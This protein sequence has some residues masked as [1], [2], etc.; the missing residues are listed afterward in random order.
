MGKTESSIN[1]DIYLSICP[2][3]IAARGDFMVRMAG[4]D[5]VRGQESV[6]FDFLGCHRRRSITEDVLME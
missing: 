6:T 1:R 3:G 5:S 2:H 4:G